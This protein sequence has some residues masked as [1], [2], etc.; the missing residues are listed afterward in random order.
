[1]L[2]ALLCSCSSDLGIFYPDAETD[3]DAA[4]VP[5]VEDTADMVD[6]APDEPLPDITP[7]ACGPSESRIDGECVCTHGGD[8]ESGGCYECVEDSHCG[9]LLCLDHVCSTCGSDADCEP[10]VC[11]LDGVCR[12]YVEPCDDEGAERCYGN[13]AERCEGGFWSDDS[14]RCPGGCDGRT[15]ECYIEPPAG[16]TGSPC[17][18]AAECEDL[19]DPICLDALD[20]F[21]DGYCT[22][23]CRGVCHQEDTSFTAYCI[24][25]RGTLPDGLCV[26][27][28][29]FL[30][31]P[32]IG[33]RPDYECLVTD[34][35]GLDS[36]KPVC[37]P[38]NWRGN[39]TLEFRYGVAS[40][41]VSATSATVW[42]NVGESKTEPIVWYGTD[43]AALVQRAWPDWTDSTDGY[44]S[45]A[46]LT[47]LAP[48]TQYFYQFSLRHSDETSPLGSFTTAPELGVA[49]DLTFM[50]TA[51]LS[52]TRIGDP[53]VFV[54]PWA[55]FS[56]VAEH[57][58]EFFVSLGDWPPRD[59]ESGVGDF[60]LLHRQ[61]RAHRE[62]RDLL[63]HTPI[64]AIF[65][66][67]EVEPEWGAALLERAS[68]AG[69]AIRSWSHWF[70]FASQTEGEFYRRFSWGAIDLFILDSRTHRD[71]SSTTDYATV[72]GE[73][74]MVWLLT[75][76]REST[77]TW[78]LV[79]TT[80]SVGFESDLLF[81]WWSYRF[82]RERLFQG[83][84]CP[85]GDCEHPI[86]NV[87]F[88]SGG[89]LIFSA[90]HHNVGL[91]EFEVG[92]ITSRPGTARG[93]HQ[94]V[95]FETR[96]QNFAIVRYNAADDT[97]TVAS[98]DYDQEGL[99]PER[100][101]EV[102]RELIRPG[103]GTVEVTS[104][105]GIE[106][107]FRLCE[108]SDMVEA[109]NDGLPAGCAH[110][111]YGV[112]P[113]R[114]ERATPGPY[115]VHWLGPGGYEIVQSA[116]RCLPDGGTISFDAVGESHDL[117]WSDPF[118][119]DLGWQVVDEGTEEGPSIWYVLAGSFI[120]GSRIHDGIDDGEALPKL[121]TLAWNGAADWTDY[122]VTASFRT[123]GF[124]AVGL[125]A[126]FVDAEHYY[127]FSMDQRRRYARILRRDG[128]DWT[129]LAEL[130]IDILFDSGT[131]YDLWFEVDGQELSAGL[132]DETIVS[133]TDDGLSE[134]AVGVYTWDNADFELD[135]VV[136]SLPE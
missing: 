108:P 18:Q 97:L 118:D 19:T 1:M 136:V 11:A 64:Y 98:H 85:R 96:R 76:L 131:W 92:P 29:N 23:E 71:P 84:V 40:G 34:E 38:I 130:E 67:L 24:D 54:D 74:Q 63:Q 81:N 110:T 125:I 113:A 79:I 28:C 16:F 101:L 50:V 133:A 37:L 112:T 109:C 57:R 114:F 6:V 49:H 48:D 3:S 122:R 59:G 41:D 78:K 119:Q 65:D 75:G 135:D 20:G 102:Y 93:G 9:D 26:V 62:V 69:N 17:D 123:G 72:L 45:Q 58:P 117:P 46:T 53:F 7:P 77:A 116:D 87:V 95:R 127:R 21:F 32:D 35:L 129:L 91:K 4:D 66:D 132:G 82:E 86:E 90:N 83:I 70:P 68:F 10:L 100:S 52:D 106:A 61:V 134:G 104:S 36:D 88:F 30:S 105:L 42:A 55:V 27:A 44:N 111:F 2:A 115:R 14:E 124:S 56:L 8:A 43:P 22:T 33:C 60:D 99:R 107:R 47:D 94:S 15:E 89:E 103:Q 13:R 25:A 39:P 126:R 12:S 80:T 121:G 31:F 5:A 73:D 120:Q 128:D 51:G